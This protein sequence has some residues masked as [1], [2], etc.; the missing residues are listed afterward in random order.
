VEFARDGGYTALRD[1][2]VPDGAVLRFPVAEWEEFLAA[3]RSGEFDLT[4]FLGDQN[5]GTSGMG[6]PFQLRPSLPIPDSGR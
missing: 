5:V 4:P 1:S 3:V 2:T 6:S